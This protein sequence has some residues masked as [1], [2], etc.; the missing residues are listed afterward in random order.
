MANILKYKGYFARIEYSAEDGV[1]Y[2]KIEGI[3]DLVNFESDSASEIENEF[4][5]AVDD[6]L[7][8]CKELGQEPDKVYSG[9]FN[10]RIDPKLHQRIAIQ[11][12][13]NGETLNRIVEKALQFYMNNNIRNME[14]LWKKSPVESYRVDFGVASAS[15]WGPRIVKEEGWKHYA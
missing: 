4:H 14:E 6:Y 5:N 7:E 8:L 11:A 9:T 12:M 2:G 10:V 13:C 1:L 3:K 15:T